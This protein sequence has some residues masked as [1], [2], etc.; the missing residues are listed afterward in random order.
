MGNGLA[1]ALDRASFPSA[2]P[3]RCSAK[4][5]TIAGKIQLRRGDSGPMFKSGKSALCGA[6]FA[7]IL[8]LGGA[9]AD[10]SIANLNAGGLVLDKTDQIELRAE[11]LYLSAKQ[12]RVSYRFFNK[13]DQALNLTVAFPMPDITGE[14]DLMVAIPDPAS[15]NFLKFQTKVDGKPIE[16]TAE[17]RAFFKPDNGKETEI[18]DMLK[19]LGV[20]L[21]PV[22]DATV[23]ALKKLSADDLKKLTDAGYVSTDDGPTALWTLRS[24]FYRQQVF[25]AKKEVLVEQTYTPSVGATS[26]VYFDKANLTGASLAEYQKKYCTTS[27]F[28]K[29]ADSLTK[30]VAAANAAAKGDAAKTLQAEQ[31]YFGYV[32]TSGGNWAGPIGKFHLVIDKAYP[33]NLV[34]FCVDGTKKISGTKYELKQNN[35]TPTRDI[36]VLIL[37]RHV[38]K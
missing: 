26:G 3:F 13:T 17:Q 33:D 7:L 11:D 19:G 9:L 16:S 20:P 21:M 30:K 36:N 23:A 37:D 22:G 6:A 31:T 38:G 4:A 1:S 2:K 5:G 8:P 18:T 34:S 12:V 15:A 28:L 32:I 27:G 25:P 14:Q 24:K 35:Y 10:D 29:A